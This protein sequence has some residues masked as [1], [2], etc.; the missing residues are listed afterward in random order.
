MRGGWPIRRPKAGAGQRRTGN[1]KCRLTDQRQEPWGEAK[2]AGAAAAQ[3]LER[4][5]GIARRNV[6]GSVDVGLGS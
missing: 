2:G 1:A 3:T 5:E 4:V 6:L